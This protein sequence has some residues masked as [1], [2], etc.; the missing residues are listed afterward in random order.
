[1][2]SI[3]R[4]AAGLRHHGRQRKGQPRGGVE[5]DFVGV[6][7]GEKQFSIKLRNPAKILALEFVLDVHIQPPIRAGNGNA[8]RQIDLINVDALAGAVADQ[9]RMAAG[10]A[11]ASSIATAADAQSD[12]VGRA[13]KHPIGLTRGG[14]AQPQID[15]PLAPA[16]GREHVAFRR[17]GAC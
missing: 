8:G 5:I 12:A 4:R 1:M 3:G 17:V 11:G 9:K 7:V 14:I 10:A 16:R 6:G 2:F 15:M 13:L